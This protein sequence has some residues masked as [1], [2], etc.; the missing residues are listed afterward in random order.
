MDLFIVGLCIISIL[1]IS[2]SVKFHSVALQDGAVLDKW[3]AQ[4]LVQTLLLL[5]ALVVLGGV[6]L[7]TGSEG[8][9]HSHVTLGGVSLATDSEGVAHSHQ[10]DLPFAQASHTPNYQAI[11]RAGALHFVWC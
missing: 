3:V 9:A 11:E 2:S 10:P 7:A 5:L 1:E 8:V 4:C 6:S